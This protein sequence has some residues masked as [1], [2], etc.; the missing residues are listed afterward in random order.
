MTGDSPAVE[1]VK[2]DQAQRAK[3]IS[4]LEEWEAACAAAHGGA[5][6]TAPLLTSARLIEAGDKLAGALSSAV[7]GV[8][9]ED[10]TEERPWRS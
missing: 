6:I 1:R 7:L 3:V 8:S 2:A 10:R 5:A 4:L 9:L